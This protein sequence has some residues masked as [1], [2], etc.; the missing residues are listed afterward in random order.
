MYQ[1]KFVYHL[2]WNGLGEE[3]V[4]IDKDEGTGQPLYVIAE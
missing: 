2:K 1:C 4:V 3:R